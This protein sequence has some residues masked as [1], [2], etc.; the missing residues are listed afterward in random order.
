MKIHLSTVRL[1]PP[2]ATA[3]VQPGARTL[4]ASGT[5][6]LGRRCNSR[7]I[8]DPTVPVPRPAHAG[9]ARASRVELLAGCGQRGREAIASGVNAATRPA[10]RRRMARSF[11]VRPTGGGAHRTDRA[12]LEQTKSPAN[13]HPNASSE[14]SSLAPALVRNPERTRHSLRGETDDRRSHCMQAGQGRAR[15]AHLLCGALDGSGCPALFE[16]SRAAW[17]DYERVPPA[18]VTIGK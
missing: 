12:Q 7:S 10:T 18:F 16:R 17:P 15:A 8:S 5:L 11:W 9:R 14:R 3:K 1:G 13:N 2:L 6:E 4:R